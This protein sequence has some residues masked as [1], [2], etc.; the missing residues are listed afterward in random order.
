[1]EENLFVTKC[2][3]LIYKWRILM[4]QV[5][6]LQWYFENFREDPEHFEP[7]D[8]LDDVSGINAPKNFNEDPEDMETFINGHGSKVKI[9]TYILNQ[10]EKNL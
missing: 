10:L 8:L 2:V 6:E 3:E 1:M 7:Y 4:A 9:P 5:K